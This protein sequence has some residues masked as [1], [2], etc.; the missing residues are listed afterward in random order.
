[1]PEYHFSCD[2]LPTGDLFTEAK[3]LTEAKKNLTEYVSSKIS[4]E[5]I[6]QYAPGMSTYFLEEGKVIEEH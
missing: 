1:M 2:N 3:S 6:H 5:K 4:P